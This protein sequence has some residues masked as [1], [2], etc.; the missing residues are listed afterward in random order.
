MCPTINSPEAIEATE[1]YVN[2]VRNYCPPG[3]TNYGWEENRIAFEQ[4]RGAMTIDLSVNPGYAE[5][6]E[7]SLVAGKVGY[8]V[9][10]KAASTAQSVLAFAVCHPS[11]RT[12]RCL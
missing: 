9:I 10:P 7:K 5:D 12:R 6:P 8:A 4:G 1:F 11:L 3:A 2:L